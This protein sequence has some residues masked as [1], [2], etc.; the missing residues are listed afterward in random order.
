[1]MG[2]SDNIDRQRRE[3][4]PDGPVGYNHYYRCLVATWYLQ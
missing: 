3:E 4:G 1:M 2:E